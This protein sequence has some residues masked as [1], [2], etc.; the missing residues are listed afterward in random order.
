M[1][2]NEWSSIIP[3]NNKS[4]KSL[5]WSKEDIKILRSLY[6]TCGSKFVAN[7]LNRSISAVQTK[8]FKL[9]IVRRE[10]IRK[11]PGRGIISQRV[12]C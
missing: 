3:N 12:L 4:K 1:I 5:P 9:G 10:H 7:K 6:K 11:C 8:I 2:S